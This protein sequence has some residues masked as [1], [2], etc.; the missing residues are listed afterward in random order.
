MEAAPHPVPDALSYLAGEWAVHRE[1]CDRATGHSGWFS[2]RAAF[3]TGTGAEWLHVEEG[4]FEWDGVRRK[5]GRTLKLVPSADGTAEVTFTD[6]RP[7]HPLDLSSGLWT[8]WHKCGADLYK[9][10]FT[11]VS[12]DEWRLRWDVQGPAKDQLLSSVYRRAPS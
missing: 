2:G 3:R 7:F 9:G 6:G 11:V 8:A 5:A 4:I 1:L 10:T 12:P